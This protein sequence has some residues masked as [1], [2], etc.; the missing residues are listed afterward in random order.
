MASKRREL[1]QNGL[2]ISVL[3]FDD[4]FKNINFRFNRKQPETGKSALPVKPEEGISG[5][6]RYQELRYECVLRFAL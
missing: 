1:D 5:W 6:G 2:H 4:L 3:V